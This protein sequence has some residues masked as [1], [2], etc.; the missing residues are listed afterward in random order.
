MQTSITKTR[1][2]LSPKADCCQCGLPPCVDYV[3]IAKA[4]SQEAAVQTRFKTTNNM[5]VTAKHMC[6]YVCGYSIT[7][8]TVKFQLMVRVLNASFAPF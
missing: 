4:F 7:V 8:R 3:F 6:A 1:D 5:D 2:G